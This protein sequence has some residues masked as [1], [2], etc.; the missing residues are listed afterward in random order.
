MITWPKHFKESEFCCPC[1]GKS[2][3]DQEFLNKLSEA[4]SHAGVPFKINSGFRCVVHNG[5]LP[6]SSAFSSHLSGHAADIATPNS[7]IRYAILLGLLLSGFNRIGIGTNF[8]HVDD[9][10]KKPPFVIWGY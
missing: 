4:R 2:E 3:M 5:S 6:N 10:P 1:C 9:D 7:A 8:V